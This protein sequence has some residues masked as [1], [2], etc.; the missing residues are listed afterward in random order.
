MNI[1]KFIEVLSS[2]AKYL[3]IL[4]LITC[5]LT[6]LLIKDM[7]NQY[8][9]ESSIYTGITSN[10]GLDVNVQRV[11]KIVTQN[12]YNNVL[13]IL[14][15]ESLYEEVGLRLLTQHLLLT[16]P[17]NDIIS[18]K[19]FQNLQK[20]TPDKIKKLVVKGNFDKTYTNIRKAVIQDDKNFLYKI[21]NYD[22]PYYSV[23]SLS[24]IKVEQINSSDLI[25]ISYESD[26]PGICYNTIKIT[27]DV[28]IKKYS[29]I[30][31]TQKSSAVKYFQDKLDEISKKL[32]KAENRLL[33]FNVSNSV[34]NYYEQTKQVTTQHQEIELRLQDVKM[35]YESS[36]AVLK[37]IEAEI[38]KRSSVN[39]K[40]VEILNVRSQL[41][42]CNNDIARFEVN[43]EENKE[44]SIDDLYKRK[45]ALE[46]KLESAID[47]VSNYDSNSQ[48]IETQKL[49]NEWLTA[50]TNYE[51]NIASLKSMKARQI[52]FL[53]QFKRYAPLGATIKRIEREITINENE[54]LNI[55]NNLNV[56]L[57]NEQNTEMISNMRI[58]DN[59]KFPIESVSKKKL[60]IMIVFAF[61]LIFFILGVFIVELLD[62]RIKS[63]NLLN[64]LTGLEVLG[65]F[66][67]HNNKKFI[68]TEQITHKAALLIYEKIR[69]LAVT[70]KKPF[71]IQILSIWDGAGKT[72]TSQI[73]EQELIKRR[74]NVKTLNFMAAVS[75]AEL[76]D[77]QAKLNAEGLFDKYL[78]TNTYKELFA[79]DSV[80]DFIISVIPSVSRGIDNTVLIKDADLN[81]LVFNADLT[82]SEADQF[83]NNKL[84][85]LI[86]KDIYTVL[87]NAQPNNLEEL[88]GEIPK[89]RSKFRILIK[90]ILKRFTK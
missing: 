28:F 43:K 87:T 2:K 36:A 77:N 86:S 76:T 73:L 35:H 90:K 33:E 58:I 17:S 61:T 26:D 38:A 21:L 37:K 7:P 56:A 32:D 23:K 46:K 81:L 71:I 60:Y 74:Y 11:D 85:E 31:K 66:C 47:L 44:T 54:Y 12:E 50:V 84:K 3:F 39:L 51:T 30:K 9:V 59:P 68:N 52:E 45:A 48:G 15:S 29:Q 79:D 34:I 6:F 8:S 53:A 67:I 20:N 40:N 25:Q 16:K 88:Y 10:S 63:P 82:W 41:V 27:D 1:V 5:G 75:G 55:L 70:D 49:L 69:E 89:K 83:N 19:V 62:H 24:R 22:N 42:S 64:S 78:N 80:Y 65:A 57:Q 14:K 72:F 4:P 18:E 13:T